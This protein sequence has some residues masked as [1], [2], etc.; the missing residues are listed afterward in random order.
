MS[1]NLSLTEEL[2]KLEQSITLTLQEIDHN[3]SRAHRIVTT[4][5]LPIV[6]Q[7]AEHSSA[8]WEGSKFWK[9]FFEASAN[10]SL[11]RGPLDD[12]S[13]QQQSQPGYEDLATDKP[14]DDTV[15]SQSQD[16]N[17][18]YSTA[19]GE[20]ETSQTEQEEPER[21]YDDSLLD[22][23][24][25]SGS[26]PRAP[27]VRSGNEKPKFADYPSPYEKLRRELKG[28]A[29][30]TEDYDDEDDSELPPTTPSQRRRI[31]KMSMT[32]ESSPFDPTSD[33]VPRRVEKNAD[34][35]SY[36]RVFD[37]TYQVKTTFHATPA[38]AKKQARTPSQKPSWRDMD[39]PLSSPPIAAPQLHSEIF[40]SP[41]RR[42]FNQPAAP[43]TPGVSVQTPARA[44][45]RDA[46]KDEITWES[47]DEMDVENFGA[48]GELGL[49]P[50]KP[51]QFNVPSSRL[52][53]TPARDISKR[54]VADLLMTA[55]GGDDTDEGDSPSMVQMRTELEDSF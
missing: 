12:T 33:I 54:I 43:R 16:G 51:I 1:R 53:Q 32:P 31:P 14:E 50:Q 9:Q 4:S 7:Y 30:E 37:K 44:K 38:T 15:L 13:V 52:M 36:R 6:E 3:F 20:D 34:P 22:N 23:T 47:S 24:D 29:V 55:G 49:S 2:E 41:I 28:K 5:I 8:V 10:V 25:V 48:Y 35:L 18:T 40:S 42:Q 11:S 26:T 27:P 46:T 45:S 39:S 17:T 21:T 19:H